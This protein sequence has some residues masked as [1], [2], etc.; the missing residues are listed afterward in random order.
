MADRVMS[1]G[2]KKRQRT[3]D[4][5]AAERQADETAY[6]AKRAEQERNRVHR[7]KEREAATA[8]AREAAEAVAAAEALAAGSE[9]SS[10][11][12]PQSQPSQPPPLQPPPAM[13]MP[14][15][16]AA[17]GIDVDTQSTLERVVAELKAKGVLDD[18]AMSRIGLASQ[19]PPPAGQPSPSSSASA[20]ASASR[21]RSPLQRAPP[22]S[23]PPPSDPPPSDPPPSDPS[24][25]ESAP[26][27]LQQLERQQPVE[28]QHPSSP[29]QPQHSS[30]QPGSTPRGWVNVCRQTRDAAK[31][32]ICAWRD[33]TADA[34][35]E[36]PAWLE[37]A[38]RI[39]LGKFCDEQGLAHES[40]DVDGSTTLRV[41]RQQIPA[42]ALSEEQ[43]ERSAANKAAALARRAAAIAALASATAPTAAA[44]PMVAAA[45]MA[46][47]APM[48]TATAPAQAA[49][50]QAAPTLPNG[51]AT[52]HELSGVADT[53]EQ[54]E[55]SDSLGVSSALYL[56]A[57]DMLK[58]KAAL[59]EPNDLAHALRVL[60]RLSMVPMTTRLDTTS[61]MVAFLAEL[62][63]NETVRAAAEA[64]GEA[65]EAVTLMTRIASTW[66]AQ[67]EEEQKQRDTQPQ[68]QQDANSEAAPKRKR[69]LDPNCL[70]CQGRHR[71]HTCK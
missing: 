5:K 33:N 23:D 1:P 65:A 55:L 34:S 50:A 62:Q 26:P 54:R 53:A 40:V 21:S 45:P 28:P 59:E 48:A 49:P 68:R 52:L 6:K 9:A 25:S 11:P 51:Q 41:V 4:S 24:S 60:R 64:G 17:P 7:K 67:L 42:A 39:H 36:L 12:P 13:P 29:V 70:A 38:D 47:T 46:A 69:P 15:A 22:P 18:A 2:A 66:D 14:A 58:L 10:T 57:A 31:E 63:S 71:P 56:G 19:P 30:P 37:P 20:S 27:Q 8:E 3:K 32:L 16:A 61:G 35:L 44:A 43:R